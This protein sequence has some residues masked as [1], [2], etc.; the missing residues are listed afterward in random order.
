MF[1]WSIPKSTGRQEEE[2][3][4][5]IF[6]IWPLPQ[7]KNPCPHEI[8]NFC[9]LFLDHHYYTLS[10]SDLCLGVEKRILN[11]IMHFSVPV[12]DLCPRG[13]E[14]QNFGRPFLSHHYNILDFSDPC[15]GVAIKKIFRK[16][17]QFYPKVL[18][19]LIRFGVSL[20]CRCYISNLVKIGPVVLQEMFMHDAQRTT[21]DANP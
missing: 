17:H 14:I 9:R 20:P 16:I 18:F 6:T 3:K 19:P 4:Y 11:D 12:Y 5:C 7:Y 1:V 13:H 10:L 8:Y 2:K 21:T 15:L